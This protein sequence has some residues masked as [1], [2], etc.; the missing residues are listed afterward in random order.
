MT[1]LV[2]GVLAAMLFLLTVTTAFAQVVFPPDEKR[3]R[4]KQVPDVTL[5]GEDSTS[6][7]LHT[8]AGKPVVVNPVFTTCQET[9]PMIT[10]SLR[11]ALAAIG[12]P[13]VGYQ[14]LTISFDPADGPSQLREYRRRLNLPPGWKLA[15]ATPD[16]LKA[17]L[18]AIDF[19]YAALPDGGFVHPNVVA[20]LTPTLNVS[21]YLHGVDYTA[22]ELRPRLE[23][24]TRESSL[25]WHYRPFIAVAAVLAVASVVIVLYSTRKKPAAPRATG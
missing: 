4:G 20:I 21:S 19:H 14:V 6:F 18:D 9:C 22:D 3:V 10:S 1:T 25:V 23:R 15:V 8:L 11:D 7:A 13:G 24:A 16:N 12:E 17:L 5:I 2:R